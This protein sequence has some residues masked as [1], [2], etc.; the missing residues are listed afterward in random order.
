MGS[1]GPW[2]IKARGPAEVNQFSTG[3]RQG[4]VGWWWDG[5]C[6]LV[7]WLLVL[8]LFCFNI[9]NGGLGESIGME[10]FFVL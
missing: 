3:N 6:L 1:K 2:R 9:L 10:G 4:Q 5:N 8:L 7:L